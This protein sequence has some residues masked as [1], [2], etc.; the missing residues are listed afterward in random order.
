M[1]YFFE[2]P[3]ITPHSLTEQ[4]LRLKEILEKRDE[5]HKQ[6]W[7]DTIPV[8]RDDKDKDE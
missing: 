1:K 4:L 6:A 7:A 5:V 8:E 3:T 2:K